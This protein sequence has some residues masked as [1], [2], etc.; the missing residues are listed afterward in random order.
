MEE[1][2]H[3]RLAGGY[4]SIRKSWTVI[5]AP[6]CH[7]AIYAVPPPCLALVKACICDWWRVVPQL[8]DVLRGWILIIIDLES[9]S[10]DSCDILGVVSCEEDI[11]VKVVLVLSGIDRI[12]QCQR[13]L[14][15]NVGNDSPIATRMPLL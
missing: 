14:K 13:Q 6:L 2:V 9:L 10:T 5:V 8:W 1:D 7:T 12:L 11:I 4:P 3:I 15:R